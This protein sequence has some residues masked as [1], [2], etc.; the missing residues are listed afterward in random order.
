MRLC[1]IAS[2]IDGNRI[3]VVSVAQRKEKDK[4][5]TAILS[6]LEDPF[7]SQKLTNSPFPWY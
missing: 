1:H 4:A 6:C 7:N 5:R 3:A 2:R